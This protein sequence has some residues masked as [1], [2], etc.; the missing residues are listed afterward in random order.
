MKNKALFLI[1]ITFL[2][3]SCAKR[4]DTSSE[5]K[6]QASIAEVKMSLDDQKKKEFEEALQLIIL[7]GMNLE[8]LLKGETNEDDMIQGYK[9]LLDGKTADEVIEEGQRIRAEM[10]AK[11]KAEAKSEIEELYAM[12]K[13]AKENKKMLEKFEIKRSRF[14]KRKQGEYYITEQPIIELTVFNGTGHAISRAYFTGTLASPDRSVPWLKDDFNYEI[15]GGLE[16]GEEVTWYLAPNEFSDWGTVDAPR[17]AILTVEVNQLDGPDGE[18]LYSVW[19]FDED[20]HQRL[21]ALL[22]DYP[23]FRE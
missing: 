7:N 5:E 21:E 18:R 8:G 20:D 16:P 19:D 17:D 22:D 15:S 3:V 12:Q 13:E 9:D 1:T 6:M 23:E 10:E 2:F 11:K 4:I 14:Y